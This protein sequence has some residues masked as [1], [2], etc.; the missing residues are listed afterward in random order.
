MTI[1]T[2]RI[3]E[4]ADNLDAIGQNPTL[5]SVRK[6]LGGGSYTTIS[7]AMAEWRAKKSAKDAAVREVPPP[8]VTEMLEQLGIEIWTQAIQMANARLAAEREALDKERQDLEAQRREAA[9]MADQVS[10]E[11][12][13]AKAEAATLRTQIE[14]ERT[15]SRTL[16][17]ALRDRERDLAVAQARTEE[18]NTR[19]DQL[20]QQLAAATAQNAELVRAIAELKPA[21]KDSKKG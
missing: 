12:E 10:V 13:S 1:T 7:Q 4:I 3:F 6:A 2:A 19:A 8:A 18:V 11:L 5:A 15:Q 17:D 21:P 9:E 20:N 14:A 16:A